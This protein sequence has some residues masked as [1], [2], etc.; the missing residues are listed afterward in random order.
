MNAS[1]AHADRYANVPAMDQGKL[2]ELRSAV[3]DEELRTMLDLIP[4]EGL[5]AIE[6]IA[7]ARAAGDLD[8]ARQAAHGLK[9]L[10]GNFGA[11]RI[12]AVARD[13]ENGANALADLDRL[14]PILASALEEIRAGIASAQ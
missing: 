8:R 11:R 3:G 4:A 6:A 2:V 10:A 12:E 13:I 5:R 7:A 14:L 1:V 9:G